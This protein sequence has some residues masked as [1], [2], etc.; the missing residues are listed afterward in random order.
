MWIIIKRII[1]VVVISRCT[2]SDRMFWWQVAGWRFLWIRLGL[3][4]VLF[5]TRTLRRNRCLRVARTDMVTHFYICYAR[6][7]SASSTFP[8][9]N[10]D[11]KVKFFVGPSWDMTAAKRS[12]KLLTEMYGLVSVVNE[13]WVLF[14]QNHCASVCANRP[15]KTSYA[16]SAR[17]SHIKIQGNRRVVIAFANR[18]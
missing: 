1:V 6:N 17:T 4:H 7:Q 16:R 9:R 5:G 10:V 8:W 15:V 2:G 12:F 13:L 18:A 14:E 3:L 11:L